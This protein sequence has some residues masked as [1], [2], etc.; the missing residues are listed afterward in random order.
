MAT[1][2]KN[3][4]AH[5]G[6][7]YT[8]DGSVDLKGKPVLRSETGTWKAC[9]FIIGYEI[10]E[11]MAF[12]GIQS[13]LVSYL[14]RK[15]LEGTVTSANNVTNWSGTVWITPILGAYI[16][17]AYL[18]RYWTF[19][20]ASATYLLGM[21]LLTLSVS[22]PALKPPPCSSKEEGCAKASNFQVGVFY[23]ALYIIAL[24]AG[25]TKPIISTIGADQFDNFEP[26]EKNQ[27]L[28]F[29]N[30]WMIGIVIGI[31]ISY[32]FLV[33]I[34]DNVGFSLG[35]GI[36]TVALAIAVLVFLIGTPLYR[37]KVASGS[38]LTKIAQVLVAAAKKAR[39]PIP[40]DP[41]ELYELSS[42]EY[43]NNRKLRIDRTP[44]LRISCRFL[45]KAAVK[46]GPNKPWNLCPVTQVEETKQ[47][48]KM[49]PVLLAT[50]IPSAYVAQVNTLFVKQGSTM[51]RSIG[52]HFD[53]PPASLGVFIT[54]SMLIGLLVYDRWFVPTIRRYTKNPRGITLMQRMGAGFLM[55]ILVM[56]AA[57]LA[58]RKRLS[59]ARA[60]GIFGKNQIVPIT[61]FFL[62]PQFIL[63]GIAEAF[64]EVALLEFF[65]DQAPEAMKSIGASYY[66]SSKGVG[67][68]L[69]TFLLTTV[70][71]IT[72]KHGHRGWILDNLNIS[73]I[74]YFYAFL[75][76]L[77]I[78]NFI[79]FILVSK[80]F[81]YN[82]EFENPKMDLALETLPD[83]EE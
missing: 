72:K 22:V 48:I 65:Y 18:G 20:S 19:V 63:M 71:N 55:H 1:I 77:S 30:W 24:A 31:L 80:L 8:Q 53:V 13:N 3:R 4:D 27:K 57:C 17:D 56:V 15:L 81:I 32:T 61:I 23:C 26:K 78:L 44:S 68:F 25:G 59:V 38:P 11:R 54:I 46:S 64:I 5:R 75:V 33:Y 60:N 79:F 50:F 35:Y 49:I 58:E 69:S 67:Y 66:T 6:E 76:V 73:H 2:E 36:P 52:P 41:K 43:S 7:D 45:D 28:S 34:Q 40:N 9:Y 62:L 83:N 14:T 39:V 12:H 29:F 10:L 16:A 47:M 42:E 21:C 74:D 70:S 51:N 82:A 37:H